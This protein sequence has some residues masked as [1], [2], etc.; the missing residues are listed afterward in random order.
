MLNFLRIG[1]GNP[2]N[3]LE[4]GSSSSQ[5]PQERKNTSKFSS[6]VTKP[7]NFLWIVFFVKKFVEIIKTYN[8]NQ[9]LSRLTEYHYQILN[10]K[11]FFPTNK[12]E[13]DKIPITKPFHDLWQ[14]TKRTRRLIKQLTRIKAF[15]NSILI[16]IK[17]FLL[18]HFKVFTPENN[19]R[20]L[21]DF[22]VLFSLVLNMFFIPLTIGFEIQDSF[23]RLD[24]SNILCNLIPNGVFMM[25]MLININ[26]A[27]YSKGEYVE[28]RDQILRNYLRNHI[29]IDLLTIGPVIL[30]WVASSLFWMIEIDAFSLLRLV[31]IKKLVLKMD[32]Y[33]H[34]ENKA[35]GGF[36]LIKLLFVNVFVAHICCCIWNY[37]GIYEYNRFYPN[38]WLSRSGL[39]DESLLTRY[40]AC[41]YWSVTTMITVGYGDIIALTNL[42]RVYCVGVML[43]CC[44]VFAYS[45]NA[46]GSIFQQMYE[47]DTQFHAKL[48]DISYYMGLRGIN[49]SLQSKIKRYL[50]YMHEEELY[51]F[52]RGTELLG[53]LSNKLQEEIS[54]D[55]YGKILKGIRIFKDNEFQGQ[56]LKK[57]AIR[58]QEIT[59]APGDIIFLEKEEDESRLYFIM[60][61]EIELFMRPSIS[62]DNEACFSNLTVLKVKKKFFFLIFNK[63]I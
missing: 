22:I 57:V 30:H 47:K 43:L 12:S 38:N 17:G 40:I 56:F 7:K 14:R 21:W 61:G 42:E 8:L 33:L 10:D 53:G 44:G 4:S 37:I 39:I 51:G 5:K 50:E 26:T 31:K 41:F 2:A 16:A 63:K 9:K 62:K 18:K 25:D 19:I 60:K 48:V 15:I 45:L 24:L 6:K 13:R 28:K 23:L 58:M 55:L 3:A 11:S 34:L 59:F 36:E 46:V 35:Q 32:E 54:E 49:P 52:Q 1:T 29:Y 20:I 27:Y